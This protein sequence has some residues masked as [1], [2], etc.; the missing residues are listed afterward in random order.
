MWGAP[1]VARLERI[2][3][4][5]TP[6]R[7]SEETLEEANKKLASASGVSYGTMQTVLKNDV[8]LSPYKITKAQLL[9]Q[10]TKTKRLQ[11]AKLLLQN[12]RDGTQLSLLWT[13][14]K[15]FTVQ[16]FTILKMTGFMQWLRVPSPWMTEWCFGDRNLLLVWSGP[17]W[18]PPERRLSS[19]S[20]KRGLR[21][22]SMYIWTCWRTSLFP[23]LIPH[24]V[25]VELFSSR[26]KPRPT[27]LIASRSGA[28]ELWLG[29]GRRN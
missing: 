24:S 5:K 6:E 4:S 10:A 12:L 14:E 2:N 13:D 19:S 11:R 16:Q 23:G 18:L 22:I 25:V 20:L 17:G 8:N 21:W 15:L 28:R 26:R 1:Q 7:R 9:L 29:S 3:S 27:Q